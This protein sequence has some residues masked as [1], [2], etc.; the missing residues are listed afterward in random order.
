MKLAPPLARF[1]AFVVLTVVSLAA[2]CGTDEVGRRPIFGKIQG[3]EGRNG[4]ITLVPSAGT[5]GPSATASVRDGRYEFDKSNGPVSGP[6]RAQIRLDPV[7]QTAAAQAPA[8]GAKILKDVVPQPDGTF[9]R[10]IPY[11]EFAVDVIVPEAP[12]WKVDLPLP[13]TQ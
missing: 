9:D 7:A 3:A 2:G 5:N 12:P 8:S 11:D 1:F 13:G 10:P 6:H 4:A